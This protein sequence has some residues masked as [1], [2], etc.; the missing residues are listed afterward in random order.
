MHATHASVLQY[1]YIYCVCCLAQM[2]LPRAHP[3]QNLQRCKMHIAHAVSSA[4]LAHCCQF[5][6]N[7]LL[8]AHERHIQ[9]LCWS[10]FSK[11]LSGT[12]IVGPKRHHAVPAIFFTYT[13]L[14]Q[15]HLNCLV[16]FCVLFPQ[17]FAEQPC[18]PCALLADCT[19]CVV[20]GD[21]S[22][23][24]LQ[25]LQKPEN[26]PPLAA[27]IANSYSTALLFYPCNNTCY[28]NR[29]QNFC[30]DLKISNLPSLAVGNFV[31]PFPGNVL[32]VPDLQFDLF[33]RLEASRSCQDV[34]G[35]R[36]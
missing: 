13:M 36:R 9:A 21:T 22:T 5:A 31:T 28:W 18:R 30:A 23:L 24:R 8:P 26:I 1:G 12:L 29:Q 15:W 20:G 27:L 14:T 25:L 11:A 3:L 19:S 10:C 4:R 2:A 16:L 7:T 6:R 17:G 32:L 34:Q 35:K 33:T